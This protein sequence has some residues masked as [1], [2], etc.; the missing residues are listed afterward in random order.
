M[1]KKTPTKNKP[2][3]EKSCKTQGAQLFQEKLCP[4]FFRHKVGKYALPASSLV[5]PGPFFFPSSLASLLIIF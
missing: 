2:E 5:L 4:V 3:K 1:K